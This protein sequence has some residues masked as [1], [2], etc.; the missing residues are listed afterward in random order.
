[1]GFAAFDAGLDQ[2]DVIVDVDG[3]AMASGVLQAALKSRK[4]GDR[5]TITFKRRGGATGTATITLKEDPSLE[6]VTLES[7]G[8]TL[9]AGQKRF[10]ESWRIQGD[11]LTGDWRPTM[12]TNGIV[13]MVASIIRVRLPIGAGG[14]TRTKT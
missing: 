5:L 2:G 8:G 3:K 6:A 12:S 9:T 4:P 13:V 11:A 10:R 1:M 14:R 7:T